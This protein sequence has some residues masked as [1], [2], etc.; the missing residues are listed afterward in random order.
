MPR[1]MRL[2]LLMLFSQVTASCATQ[3]VSPSG[4]VDPSNAATI[5]GDSEFNFMAGI[6]VVIKE[7]DGI[8][9]KTSV[10][11]VSVS[12]GLHALTVRCELISVGQFYMQ[13]VEVDAVPKGRYVL[14]AKV[15]GGTGG[16][17]A[18]AVKEN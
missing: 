17:T 16:C 8:P 2:T 13:T 9:I 6:A 5:S 10:T 11:H 1:Y 4:T 12:P 3:S 7:V 14:G 18:V 15:G